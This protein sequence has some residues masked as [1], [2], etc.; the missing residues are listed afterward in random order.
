MCFGIILYPSCDET[1]QLDRF[2]NGGL[3]DPSPDQICIVTSPLAMWQDKG[4]AHSFNPA[5]RLLSIVKRTTAKNKSPQDQNKTAILVWVDALGTDIKDSI[6]PIAAVQGLIQLVNEVTAAAESMTDDAEKD[7]FLKYLKPVREC[8]GTESLLL[9]WNQVRGRLGPDVIA[10]LEFLSLKLGSQIA[11]AKIEEA[12]LSQWKETLQKLKQ[13][14][15]S[16]NLP[17]NAIEFLVRQVNNLVLSL[18]AYSMRGAQGILDASFSAA[19]VINFVSTNAR[20]KD[21]NT[22]RKFKEIVAV[23]MI[24]LNMLANLSQITGYDAKGMVEQLSI[25]ANTTQRIIAD[26]HADTESTTDTQNEQTE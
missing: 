25:E 8:M 17:T 10:S 24:T 19:G 14:V 20:V 23:I 9:P 4:M 21:H 13:E 5:Y 2:R 3:S 1:V 16:S 11:E 6:G 15:L 22:V 18:D 12:R 7:T 26:I